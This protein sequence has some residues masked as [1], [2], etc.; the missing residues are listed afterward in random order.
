MHNSISI[1][2]FKPAPP[3]KLPESN[4]PNKDGTYETK[5]NL[6]KSQFSNKNLKKCPTFSFPGHN[7]I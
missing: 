5:S 2:T 4:S 6:T 3:N 7:N 1:S